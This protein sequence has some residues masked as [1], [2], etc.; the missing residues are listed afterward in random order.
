MIRHR[1]T[2]HKYGA[3]PT[4][5]DG[6]RF[7]SIKE[8]RYYSTLKLAQKTGELLFFIRQVP[9]HL[10]GGTKLVVDFVEFWSDGEVKI[11]DVKGMKTDVYKLKKR[12]VEHHYPIKINEV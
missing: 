5:I 7:D 4:V 11:T 8:A 9:F 10:P 3:K 1:F 2:G 6:I 12:E